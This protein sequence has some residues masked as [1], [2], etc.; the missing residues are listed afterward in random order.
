MKHI[1][2]TEDAFDLEKRAVVDQWDKRANRH[3]P[4][5]NIAA[6]KIPGNFRYSLA[7]SR[8]R[9]QRVVFS[10]RACQQGPYQRPDADAD[11]GATGKP[12]SDIDA[13]SE[14]AV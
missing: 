5:A 10:F 7:A 12:C 3:A 14:P 1:Q 4:N 11:A 8:Q 2:R 13:D 6:G 9:A